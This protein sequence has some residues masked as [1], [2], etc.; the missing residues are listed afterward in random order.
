MRSISRTSLFALR[1]RCLYCR[2][3]SRPNS[4]GQG[5]SDGEDLP[6]AIADQ[7]AVRGIVN[8]GLDHEGIGPHFLGRLRFQPVA[9]VDDRLI[10]LVDGLGTQQIDVPLD[11]PP[12]EFLYVLLLALPVADPHELAQGVVVLGEILELVVV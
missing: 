6:Q 1:L 7:A 11:P 8:I 4:P 3:P 9:F 10:D 12:I 2:Q 5:R